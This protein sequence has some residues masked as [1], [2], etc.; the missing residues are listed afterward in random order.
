MRFRISPCPGDCVKLLRRP[1]AAA[2][3]S[4]SLFIASHFALTCRD[5]R[6]IRGV[7]HHLARTVFQLILIYAVAIP[8]W[9]LKMQN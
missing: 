5:V 9:N 8:N 7:F 3:V 6:A 1:T 4:R 2:I